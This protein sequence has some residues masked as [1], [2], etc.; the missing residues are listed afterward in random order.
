[1]RGHEDGIAEKSLA[2][3]AEAAKLE[4][5][6]QGATLGRRKLRVLR[7]IGEGSRIGKST[8]LQSV[9]QG[10]GLRNGAPDRSATAE[11]LP[12]R[13]PPFG[14]PPGFS[15][16]RVAAMLPVL[17][18]GLRQ[19]LQTAARRRA[20]RQPPIVYQGFRRQGCRQFQQLAVD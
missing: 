9:L 13:G 8:F 3:D 20:Q 16:N 7:Q 12:Q 1:N 18:R 14:G 4:Q 2:T 10:P 11:Q 17:Q 6:V 5:T 15:A 19:E